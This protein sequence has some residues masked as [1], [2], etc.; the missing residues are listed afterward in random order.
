MADWKLFEFYLLSYMLTTKV[1][2]ENLTIR[3]FREKTH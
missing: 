3:N 1:Q 2:L